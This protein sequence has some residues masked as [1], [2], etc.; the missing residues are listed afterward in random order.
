MITV[1]AVG[2]GRFLC[3]CLVGCLDAVQRL[4]S[5]AVV[6]VGK[7]VAW[8]DTRSSERLVLSRWTGGSRWLD[9]VLERRSDVCAVQLLQSDDVVG[10]VGA[11]WDAVAV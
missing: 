10:R 3:S 6:T 11:L 5:D 9:G 4:L 1:V 8:V 2:V 7:S